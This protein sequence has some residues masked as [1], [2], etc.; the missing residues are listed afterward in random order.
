MPS[1]A[2]P[3]PTSDRRWV[4]AA[5]LAFHPDLRGAKSTIAVPAATTTCPVSVSLPDSAGRHAVET[6]SAR[7]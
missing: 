1:L 7:A 5:N 4:G 3:G 6:A 2:T